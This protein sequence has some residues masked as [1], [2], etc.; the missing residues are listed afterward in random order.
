M[1]VK[2]AYHKIPV[3]DEESETLL[4]PAWKFQETLLSRTMSTSAMVTAG[5]LAVAYTLLVAF[6][7]TR[8]YDSKCQGGTRIVPNVLHDS[9]KYESTIFEKVHDSD[10]HPYFGKPN[11]ELDHRW[12]KLMQCKNLDNTLNAQLIP[13]D[14]DVRVP[15]EEVHRFGRENEAVRFPDGGYFGMLTAHH[16]LHC[17]VSRK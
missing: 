12:H 6:A 13:V 9:I 5:V 4:R 2:D 1:A 10:K 16:N 17:L 8:F 14:A 7:A 11:E 3:E 15:D